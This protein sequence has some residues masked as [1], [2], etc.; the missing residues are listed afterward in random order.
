V[1]PPALK[2]VRNKPGVRN[3]RYYANG[4]TNG[5]SRLLFRRRRLLGLLLALLA[6]LADDLRQA[7]RIAARAYWRAAVRAGVPDGFQ[8]L[9]LARPGL[10]H[11][12]RTAWAIALRDAVAVGLRLAGA[13]DDLVVG[14][15]R[16]R[17]VAI[18]DDLRN[19]ALCRRRR[20][21]CRIAAGNR[22]GRSAHQ[23]G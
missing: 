11:L 17:V 3:K 9:R 1:S 19:A 20:R 12:R 23:D 6:R 5:P 16:A 10:A 15:A 7:A 4:R 21:D 13:D 8:Y 22:H 18:D 14:R 2:A